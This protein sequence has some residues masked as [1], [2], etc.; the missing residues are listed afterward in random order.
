M[1][2]M[3]KDEI[4]DRVYRLAF[5]YEK[6]CRGC[7]QSTLAALQDVFDIRDDTTFRS[8]SGLSGGIG[9]TTLGT[10][11]ALTGC[12]MAIGMLFG[13]E[14]EDFKDEG[15]KRMVA[16]R[17]CKQL[18]ERFVQEY[19]SVVCGE[20]QKTHLGSHYDLWDPEVYRNFDEVA[21]RREKC[22][23]LV[24]IAAVWAAEIILE[25]LEHPDG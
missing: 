10:C 15:K 7:A 25:S 18:A 17:L 3:E 1:L 12:S 8:A 11:G 16:Y 20:I 14:R 13:R 23:E 4:L 21:Y 9:L 2:L 22:P 5:N 19:G 6:E 24:G